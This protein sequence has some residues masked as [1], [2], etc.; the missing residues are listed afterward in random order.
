M[1]LQPN[2]FIFESELKSK[3]KKEDFLVETITS[4]LPE[5]EVII[6]DIVPPSPLNLEE[7]VE[8]HLFENGVNKFP[9][10]RDSKEKETIDH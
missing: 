9:E 4:D 2:D 1:N 3:V 6:P 8:K 5:I 7:I 10:K